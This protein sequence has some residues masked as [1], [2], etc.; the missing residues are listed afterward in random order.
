VEK[1]REKNETQGRVTRCVAAG[2]SAGRGSGAR[3]TP[4]G[5]YDA[6]MFQTDYIQNLTEFSSALILTRRCCIG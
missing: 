5:G 3:L 1:Q 4:N 2:R 6:P